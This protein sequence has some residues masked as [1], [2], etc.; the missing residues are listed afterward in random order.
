M[1][2]GLSAED[3]TLI[4]EIEDLCLTPEKRSMYTDAAEAFSGNEEKILFLNISRAVNILSYFI[5]FVSFEQ[6]F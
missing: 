5:F 6:I 2:K 4:E 3:K 1:L